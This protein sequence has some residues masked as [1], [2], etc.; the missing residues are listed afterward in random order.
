MWQIRIILS[1]N[2][3]YTFDNKT[4]CKNDNEMKNYNLF[5]QN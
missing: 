2:R 1:N 3:Q 4:K 5:N